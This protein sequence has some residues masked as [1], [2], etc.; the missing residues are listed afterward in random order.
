MIQPLHQEILRRLGEVSELSEDVRFG[1][2]VDFLGFLAQD[3]TGRTIA[4]IEDEDFLRAVER[5]R[6]NLLARQ[7]STAE[8]RA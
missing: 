1:Q 7:S 4:E 2:M 8:P 5:H 6:E 3:A